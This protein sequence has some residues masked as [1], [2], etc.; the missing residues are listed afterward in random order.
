MARGGRMARGGLIAA[1]DIGTTTAKG[2]LVERAR[3]IVHE[4]TRSYATAYP[5]AGLVEQDPEDWWRAV[6][7]LCAAFWRAGYAPE[8]VEAAALTGQMQDVILLA[9]DNTA[10]RPAILYSDARAVAQAARLRALL[11]AD[12]AGDD[13]DFIDGTSPLAKLA[14]LR[15]HEAGRLAACAHVVFNAKDYILARL[16]GACGTDATTAATTGLFDLGAGD[17]RRAW[18]ALA[19]VSS[20]LLPALVAPDAVA[21]TVS[22]R[23]AAATGLPEGTPAYGG[24]GDAA[25]ATLSAGVT[26]PGRTYL[27]LG[28]S[29]WAATVTEMVG[30]NGRGD[31]GDG[32]RGG[33]GEGVRYLPYVMPGTLIKVAPLL[34]AGGAHRWIV[35]LV[36]PESAAD[37]EEENG[38][39]AFER[40]LLDTP[41]RSGGALFL[42]YLTGERSPVRETRALGTF[43][44][45]GVGTGRGALGWA[46]L[47]G[48]CFA[49]R[50]VLEALG[51][52]A[53]RVTLVGG[54]ARSPLLRQ[55]IADIC[56]V[57]V[58]VR[59]LPGAAGAL[60]AA[61]PVAVGQGW[62]TSV[63]D[64]VAAWFGGDDGEVV[65]PQP[66]RVAAYDRLYRS[67]VRIYPA[68]RLLEEA[69]AGA[70]CSTL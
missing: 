14:W 64:G 57:R 66:D 24:M 67:Y 68:I 36:A 33:G 49:L 2:V 40:L 55:L 25:A 29:G 8:Q 46:A 39:A 27:Y 28:T 7:D 1:F 6:R 19:G 50:Q 20:A 16:S 41:G 63:P 61:V 12:E 42:P 18:C 32:S 58:H 53:P 48:V 9:R 30:A 62:F 26:A 15:D 47:E 52:A 70:G 60:A 3:G 69:D 11:P 65:D 35:D 56:A 10:V 22:A 44:R 43:V 13:L 54:M 17:W 37:Q 5:A 38:Y 21:G 51:S 31:A 4:E 34:N 23:G 45:L 59:A